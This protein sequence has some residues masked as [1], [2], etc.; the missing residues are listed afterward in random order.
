MR[1]LDLVPEGSESWAMGYMDECPHAWGIGVTC[2][3][4]VRPSTQ[5]GRVKQDPDLGYR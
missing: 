5:W 4:I 1:A 3:C 2:C